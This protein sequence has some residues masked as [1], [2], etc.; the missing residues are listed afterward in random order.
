VRIRAR[1]ISGQQEKRLPAQS[2]MIPPLV[3]E[4]KTAADT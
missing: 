1:R 4:V 2:I 3:S